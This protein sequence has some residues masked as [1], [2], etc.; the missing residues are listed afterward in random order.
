MSQGV[1]TLPL[2]DSA[3]LG[4]NHGWESITLAPGRPQSAKV[5]VQI[6]ELSTTPIPPKVVVRLVNFR[7]RV[8]LIK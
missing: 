3:A 5:T 1:N 8:P 7:I 4:L 6:V 2:A